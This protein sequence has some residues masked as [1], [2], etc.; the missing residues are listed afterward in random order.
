VQWLFLLY[1]KA[2]PS[3][4]RLLWLFTFFISLVSR[5]QDNNDP[6]SPLRQVYEFLTQN[7]QPVDSAFDLIQLSAWEALAYLEVIENMQ[8]GDL[9]EAVPDYY[10]F[11]GNTLTIKLMDPETNE[12]GVEFITPFRIV[13]NSRILLIDGNSGSVRDEW[14]I[15][16]MDRHYLALH[17]GELKVF[18]IHTPARE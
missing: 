5:A 11:K 10:H 16:G 1:F 7:P 18:F 2:M 6:N 9:R 3:R 8:T 12:Y 14:S 13:D 15:I 17:M 4:F